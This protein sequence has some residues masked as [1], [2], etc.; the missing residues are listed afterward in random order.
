MT[1]DFSYEILESRRKCTAF[2][3][4]ERKEQSTLN[5]ISGENILQK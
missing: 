5:S 4:A 2:S 1:V 3:G